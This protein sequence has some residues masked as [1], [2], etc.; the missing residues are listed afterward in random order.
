[1][2]KDNKNS[3]AI[4]K[5]SAESLKQAVKNSDQSGDFLGIRD[6]PGS[7]DGADG[8]FVEIEQDMSDY[9]SRRDPE[10]SRYDE[11]GNPVRTQGDSE[12]DN[13]Y[14]PEGKKISDSVPQESL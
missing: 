11:A 14:N 13:Y 4:K 7:G 1:M 8:K 5:A 6:L 9:S 2:R 3:D 12:M 10:E